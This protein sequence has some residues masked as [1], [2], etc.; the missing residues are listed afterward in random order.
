MAL[1]I[2]THRERDPI[3]GDRCALPGRAP[4]RG[5]RTPRRGERVAA[6]PAALRGGRLGR[7]QRELGVGEAAGG[8]GL[9]LAGQER[10][11]GL[12]GAAM[13]LI[14]LQADASPETERDGLLE[15]A[16]TLLPLQLAGHVV[17][18][19]GDLLG[20]ATAGLELA[21]RAAVD[22]RGG[23]VGPLLL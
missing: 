19:A 1:A 13:F 3:A 12:A 4:A 21:D 2:E 8:Q 18:Q 9:T 6:L 10:A 14:S 11:G 15:D 16:L 20:R 17:P 7:N 22:H 23:E 5:C